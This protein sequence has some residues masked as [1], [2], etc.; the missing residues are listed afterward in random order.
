MAMCTAMQEG[1]KGQREQGQVERQKPQE[2]L[3]RNSEPRAA[4]LPQ[5]LTSLWPPSPA[6]QDP[7]ETGLAAPTSSLRSHSSRDRAW[8]G[9]KAGWGKRVFFSASGIRDPCAASA[10]LRNDSQFLA[11]P[12]GPEFF[13]SAQAAPGPSPC[14]L[15]MGKL[16]HRK[17]GASELGRVTIR[18]EPRA[19]VA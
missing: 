11:H 9:P 18:P 12:R 13:P 7:L 10:L 2:T 8:K 15:Q 6:V 17:V 19:C 4:F 1:R 5:P 16:G 14:Y 3:S